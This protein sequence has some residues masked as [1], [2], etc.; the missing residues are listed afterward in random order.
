MIASQP[1]SVL[2]V[3]SCA[4]QI[5]ES[6][7]IFKGGEG[8]A[9]TVFRRKAAAPGRP[10]T[11][12]C[13]FS[14]KIRGRVLPYLCKNKRNARRRRLLYNL[15]LTNVSVLKGDLLPL[16][17]LSYFVHSHYCYQTLPHASYSPIGMIRTLNLSK[18]LHL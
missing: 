6:I 3:R 11:A 8:G 9:N 12:R 15:P 13:P 1:R 4:T 14:A 7:G 17:S 18:T 10:H 2:C 5:S 16:S